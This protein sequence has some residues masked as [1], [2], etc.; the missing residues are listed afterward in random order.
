MVLRS[1][2]ST[3]DYRYSCVLEGEDI[4]GHV[5][6][7]RSPVCPLVQ[8]IRV[9]GEIGVVGSMKVCPPSDMDSRWSRTRGADNLDSL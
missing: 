4:V 7:Q 6:T 2:Y 5:P 8:R 1:L 3:T 9:Q